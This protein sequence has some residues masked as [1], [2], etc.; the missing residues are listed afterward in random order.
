IEPGMRVRVPLGRQVR[1]GVVAGFAEAPPPG[2]L[3]SILDVLDTDPF[4]PPDLLELC[5]WTARY[6]LTTLAEVIG[7]I[8]P[9]AVPVPARER[10]VALARRLD[11]DAEAALARRAPARAAAYRALAARPDGVLTIAGARAAGVGTAALRALIAA[12]LA[13]AATRQA[14]PAPPT[15]V[16]SRDLR[17]TLTPA[18]R[19]A[20]DAIGAALDAGT[21]ASFLLHGVTGSGKTE[22]FLTAA[23]R[24]RAA[25]RD[26]VVLVPEI[27]LTHQLVERVRARF[28]VEVAV[29]HSGLGPRERWQEWRRIRGA[30]AHVGVGARSAVFAPPARPGRL[31][32]DEEHDGAYKQEEGLRYN[33]RDLAVVRARLAGG[34]VVLASATPSAESH[35]AARV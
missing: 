31:V 35:Q 32:V 20:A 10:V 14:A 6:Y 15:A 4:L 27:A 11:P 2:E 25:G 12:G 9:A 29:L 18:Q 8:V 21:P 19:A 5:R 34:V 28:G 26:V 30:L 7:A 33:A 1:T 17:P 22:V 3:R 24:A 16:P 13:T 23:A